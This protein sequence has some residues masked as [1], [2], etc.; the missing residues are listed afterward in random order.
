MT[1]H[2][3]PSTRQHDYYWPKAMDEYELSSV[4]VTMSGEQLTAGHAEE[5]QIDFVLIE[6]A[7]VR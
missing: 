4:E 6:P 7:T 2:D 3:L 1:C 5:R